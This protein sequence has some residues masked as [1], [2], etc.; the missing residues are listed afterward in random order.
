M[1]RSKINEKMASEEIGPM[2]GKKRD[3]QISSKIFK[4][5]LLLS[6]GNRKQ[7]EFCKNYSIKIKEKLKDKFEI[8]ILNLEQNIKI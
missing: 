5:I 4:K 1:Q 8:L 2:H 6:K 3:I 7:E